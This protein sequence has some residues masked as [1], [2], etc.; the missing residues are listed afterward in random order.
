MLH[1]RSSSL[2][3]LTRT[4][5]RYTSSSAYSLSSASCERAYNLN[6]KLALLWCEERYTTMTVALQ[7]VIQK[8]ETST[9]Q[10]TVF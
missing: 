7:S 3:L 9:E 4:T 10:I 8:L 5:S 2:Q 1:T 6:I